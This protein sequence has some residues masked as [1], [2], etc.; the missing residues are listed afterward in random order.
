MDTL[1]D[2]RGVAAVAVQQLTR[3]KTGDSQAKSLVAAALDNVK[4]ILVMIDMVA[5]KAHETGT[6]APD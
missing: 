4:S 1:A 5:A 6:R 3:A 2:I